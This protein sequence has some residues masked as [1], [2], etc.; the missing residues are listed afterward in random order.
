M[1]IFNF[2]IEY[3]FFFKETFNFCK[4]A[5]DFTLYVTEII[6]YNVWIWN[7]QKCVLNN[8][9]IRGCIMIIKNYNNNIER[10]LL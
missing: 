9:I 3:A 5:L 7:F 4:N 8:N 1:Y 6:K 10:I 2:K